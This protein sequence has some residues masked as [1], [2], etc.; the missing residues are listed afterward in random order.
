M[1]FEY[2]D[3]TKD[4][5][6]YCILGGANVLAQNMQKKLTNQPSFNVRVTGI[7]LIDKMEMRVTS[8]ST[9]TQNDPQSKTYQGVFN[10]TS[11]GCMREM[12]I[13]ANLNYPTKEA[14][15]S[16][17]YGPSAK[18]GIKF[19]RAWWI[20]GLPG[21][22]ITQ[23]GLGHSDLTI[24][25]CVYP[26]Y[27][28]NVPDNTE[29]VLLCSYTWQQDA[30]R[31][32]SMMVGTNNQNLLTHA[33]IIADEQNLK[34]LVLRDLAKMHTGN[35]GNSMTEDE[36][37][38]ALQNS[39]MDHYAH[40]WT[41]D[42]NT[43]GAFAFFRPAQFST[44]WPLMIQPTNDHIIIGEAAS[45]HHA[46][47]VGALESAVYGVYSWISMN[48]ELIPGA[49]EALSLLTTAN[50]S[51]PFA[52]L[53]DYMPTSTAQWHGF[54]AALAREDYLR[55]KQA[56]NSKAEEVKAKSGKKASIP[57]RV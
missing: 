36:L 15:R 41:H 27:N 57:L 56:E 53:P 6:W 1:D 45:P 40:D 22:N 42:P 25:T 34:N 38:D 24:R 50:P 47:V 26:S 49:T 55:K 20:Y 12:D 10:S 5:G 54:I 32:G 48:E 14:M 37:Y 17:G 28:Y 23:G 21:F 52:G 8:Q 44:L 7:E 46:W 4:K 16:L 19:N 13:K 18:V 35:D 11:L 39:Y 2:P 9:A 33:Q 3:K 29:A 31:I 43:A 30:E 51:V